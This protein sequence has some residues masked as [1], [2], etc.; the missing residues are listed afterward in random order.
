MLA[1]SSTA[2]AC[3]PAEGGLVCAATNIARFN[4]NPRTDLLPLA[5][6]GPMQHSRIAPGTIRLT[7]A[8]RFDPYGRAHTHPGSLPML[9]L[10]GHPFSSYTWKALIPLYDR[11]LP[12]TFRNLGPDHPENE[13]VRAAHAGR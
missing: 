3:Q 2:L 6:V 5:G 7:P 11:A 12:F 4:A 8:R 9:Q 1:P 13:A 10:I